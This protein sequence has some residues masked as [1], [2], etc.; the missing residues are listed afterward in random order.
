MLGV[1]MFLLSP[2]PYVRVYQVSDG[3]GFDV[4][5]THVYLIR[6]QRPGKLAASGF[7]A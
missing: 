3:R 1:G 7:Q 6:R 4:T 2:I 5:A